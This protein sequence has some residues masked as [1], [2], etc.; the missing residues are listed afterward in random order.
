MRG[1]L[2]NFAAPAVPKPSFQTITFAALSTITVGDPDVAPGATASSGLTVSYISSN[3]AVAT[4]VSSQIHAVAAGSC[5]ITAIQDG[6][7]T[8]NA[9]PSVPRSLLVVSP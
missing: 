7:S 6:N 1:K 8:Y 5:V 3:E 9:A 4:I 2:G